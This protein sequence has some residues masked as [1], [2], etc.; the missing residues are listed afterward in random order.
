MRASAEFILIEE[1]LVVIVP[2]LME[3]GAG[4]QTVRAMMVPLRSRLGMTTDP[5]GVPEPIGVAVV[6]ISVSLLEADGA[7]LGVDED[8]ERSRVSLDPPALGDTSIISSYKNDRVSQ[9]QQ[10]S[11]RKTRLSG[12]RIR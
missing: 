8:A 2:V 6:D 9:P 7:P 3:A 10:G 5:V 1:R 12:I 11:T 4:S